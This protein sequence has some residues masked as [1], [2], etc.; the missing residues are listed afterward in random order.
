MKTVRILGFLVIV[1]IVVLTSTDG[2]KGFKDGWNSV[3]D[4]PT[5]VNLVSLSIVPDKS[6]KP[7]SIYNAELQRNVS[8]RMNGIETYVAHNN[9]IYNRFVPFS[10][11]FV[12]FFLYGFYSLVR[13]LIDIC[14]NQVLTKKNVKRMR[15][16]IYSF[17]LLL[18]FLELVRYIEYS[19]AVNEIILPSGY[20]FADFGLKSP[21]MLFLLLVLFVEIFAKAE[22]IKEEN[23]LTI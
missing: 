10:L 23:D 18:A 13:M 6:L 9:S 2:L 1:I 3:P 4:S 14:R 5:D 21:W 7:D 16:F 20:A 12:V 11:P 19:Q 22:K 8:Y 17:I 15:F